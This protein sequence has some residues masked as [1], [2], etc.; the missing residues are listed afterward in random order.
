MVHATSAMSY[1]LMAV[2]AI[3]RYLQLTCITHQ[4][5]ADHGLPISRG[6]GPEASL[7]VEADTV[8]VHLQR[9]GHRGLTQAPATSDAPHLHEPPQTCSSQCRCSATMAAHCAHLKALVVGGAHALCGLHNAEVQ[10]CALD[11]ASRCLAQ[12]LH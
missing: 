3:K 6:H 11:G 9:R 1:P 12:L 7:L 10:V 2:S 8:A 4:H 5:T